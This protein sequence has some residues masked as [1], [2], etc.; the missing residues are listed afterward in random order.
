MRSRTTRRQP[1]QQ[2]LDLGRFRIDRRKPGRLPARGARVRHRPRKDFPATHPGHITLSVVPG[3]P[4]LRDGDVM[5]EVEGA[6]RKGCKRNDV[7]L[8]HYSIQDD[9]AH[10]I[11]EAN[12]V[13]ALGRAMKS[14]ASL[15]AFAVNRGLGRPKGKVLRDRYHLTEL[16]SPRQV[17]NALAYVLLNARRHAAKRIARRKAMGLKNVAPLERARGVDF[18][19]SGRWFEGWRTGTLAR[20]AA[21]PPVAEARTWFLRRGWRLHGL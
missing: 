17:R 18:F 5:R 2:V 21:N 7:R 20:L 9:H 16:K 4:S 11:V 15:F 19:S 14:L 1:K 12:G 6:F 8:V 3:L 10:L 13:K